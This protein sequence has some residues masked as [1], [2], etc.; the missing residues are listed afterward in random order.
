[1]DENLEGGTELFPHIYGR[2]KMSAV[3]KVHAFP[4]DE[5]GGFSERSEISRITSESDRT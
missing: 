1:V 4:C 3:K 5:A 2:L